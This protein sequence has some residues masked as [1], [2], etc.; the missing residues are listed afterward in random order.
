LGTLNKVKTIPEQKL[1][2]Q[3]ARHQR[4]DRCRYENAVLMFQCLPKLV[5]EDPP[6]S[7]SFP[8]FAFPPSPQTILRISGCCDGPSATQDQGKGRSPIQGLKT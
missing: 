2:Y 6:H 4:S 8:P 7:I 3:R 5:S 1:G